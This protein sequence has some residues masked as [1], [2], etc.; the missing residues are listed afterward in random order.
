MSARPFQVGDRVR[1]TVTYFSRPN[2][3]PVEGEIFEFEPAGFS[4][5]GL[6]FPPYAAI[7]DENGT[8]LGSF[9]VAF[10]G[11]YVDFPEQYKVELLAPA[12]EPIY[13]TLDGATMKRH[14]TDPDLDDL[15]DVGWEEID[16][17]EQDDDGTE[18]ETVAEV[19]A[20]FDLDQR[21]QVA[22]PKHLLFGR[23][24]RVYKDRPDSLGR[25]WVDIDR[26]PD[27]M[28][29]GWHAIEPWCLAPLPTPAPFPDVAVH[30][31]AGAA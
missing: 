13:L 16:A 15:R 25:I 24:G 10:D 4:V 5:D 29:D 6:P 2:D 1:L 9:P 7:R 18:A 23:Q 27:G 11:N 21:V 20:H 31:R 8:Y 28:H 26:A 30:G 3:A 17:P 19:R 22:E 14:T 12:P